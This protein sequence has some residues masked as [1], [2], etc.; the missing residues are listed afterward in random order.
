MLD[1]LLEKELIHLERV[2]PHVRSGPFPPSY[3]RRRVAALN[4]AATQPRSRTRIARL[5]KIL[6]EIEKIA[7][8]SAA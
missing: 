6:A 8:P 4:G 5:E 1:H 2:L 7:L 3:W